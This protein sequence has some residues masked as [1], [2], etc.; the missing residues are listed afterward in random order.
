M[1]VTVA[2]IAKKVSVY[3]A[4]AD[5]RTWKS[6]RI[7]YCNCNSNC[8]ASG[9]ALAGKWAISCRLR[10]RRASTI[11]PTCRIYLPSSETQLSQM[12]S[13]GTAI[14]TELTKLNLKKIKLSKRR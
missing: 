8:I 1:S 4:F 11:P 3:L 13:D 5:K 7:D 6:D 12:E 14:E 10:K 9:N 2:A